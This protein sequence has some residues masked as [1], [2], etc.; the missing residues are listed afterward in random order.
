MVGFFVFGDIYNNK[1]FY[2]KNY[3]FNRIRI[4]RIN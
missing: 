3:T 2:E 4:D 1:K